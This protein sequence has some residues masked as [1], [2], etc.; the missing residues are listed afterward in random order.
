MFFKFNIYICIQDDPNLFKK[1][2]NLHKTIKKFEVQK[3][4]FQEQI[5]ILKHSDCSTVL[6]YLLEKKTK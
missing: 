2:S 1:G 5:N 3:F 4:E 6:Q